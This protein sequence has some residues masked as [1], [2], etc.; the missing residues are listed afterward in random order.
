VWHR[1]HSDPVSR[2]FEN[3]LECAILDCEVIDAESSTADAAGSK[4]GLRLAFQASHLL[5]AKKAAAVAIM[6]KMRCI[7]LRCCLVPVIADEDSSAVFWSRQRYS[8]FVSGILAPQ[9]LTIVTKL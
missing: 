3:N 9:R 1:D 4:F 2:S 8:A 7:M 5:Y 6:S